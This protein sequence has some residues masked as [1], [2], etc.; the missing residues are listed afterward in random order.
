MPLDVLLTRPVIV[1]LEGL[2][3]EEKALTMMFLLASVRAHA[4][5]TRRSGAPLSHVCLVEEAHTVIG[6]GDG[7]AGG[8]RANPQAVSLRFFVRMLAEM[9]A[10][11]EGLVIADQLPTAIAPEA[12]KLTNLKVMHRVVSLEDR[13]ELGQAMT[14][15][16]GQ[17]EQAA[18][19]PPGFSLVFQEGWM[20][21]RLVQEPDF[22]GEH[23]VDV[24]P[25]DG[26]V[27]AHMAPLQ[28]SD[29]PVRQ[30]YL[31]FALCGAVCTALRRTDSRG[32]ERWAS[33]QAAGDR[34]GERKRP[35]E[36][37]ALSPSRS[38]WMAWKVVRRTGSLA[39]RERPLSGA[40]A[41]AVGH[42]ELR[43]AGERE[44]TGHGTLELREIESETREQ[45]EKSADMAT[46]DR[47]PPG[48]DGAPGR[49]GGGVEGGAGAGGQ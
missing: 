49:G 7:Q 44:E 3:D 43:G 19:L 15:D 21:S 18:T 31:P 13:Q 25:E 45:D 1:E 17:L 5:T 30:A 16:A 10:L 6:R 24:P 11:G 9:R 29:E 12:L 14:L 8:E 26:A 47:G 20:R 2:S 40:G 22:K 46:G 42:Q 48:E 23:G 35:G 4:R 36:D 37:P 41:A 34:G 32:A 28:A 39:L 27:R 38:T 33:A